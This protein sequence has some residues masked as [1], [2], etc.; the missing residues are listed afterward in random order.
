MSSLTSLIVGALVEELS[1]MKNRV[2]F[3]SLLLASLILT[4]AV[5]SNDAVAQK[6]GKHKSNA[7]SAT[8][9][10]KS[11]LPAPKVRSSFDINGLQSI[12]APQTAAMIGDTVV[13]RDG[14]AKVVNTPT[15]AYFIVNQPS[16]SERSTD[17]ASDQ[18][19]R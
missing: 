6:R 4:C 10:Q 14:Q 13:S 17:R 1:G 3:A 2:S 11:S 15:G 18:K 7:K 12:G 5:T 9:S 19:R 16:S 8:T